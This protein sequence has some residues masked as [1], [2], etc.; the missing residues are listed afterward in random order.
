MGSYLCAFLYLVLPIISASILLGWLHNDGHD[1]DDDDHDDD[2]SV[3][4]PTG[5]KS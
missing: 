3:G 1:D 4:D 5:L 2:V